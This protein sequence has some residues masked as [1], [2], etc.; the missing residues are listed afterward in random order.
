LKDADSGIRKYA[1]IIT[2]FQMAG[3]GFHAGT[4]Q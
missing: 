4:A 1:Q 2:D 3:N